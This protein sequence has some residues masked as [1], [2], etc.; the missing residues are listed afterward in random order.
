MDVPKP[1]DSDH[2]YL[3]WLRARKF[4]VRKAEEM[5]RKVTYYGM[6]TTM[7][8]YGYFNAKEALHSI[9]SYIPHKLQ[10]TDGTA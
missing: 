9:I 8:S 4:N 1:E 5:L 3:R 6:A 7:H 2:Y 10:S